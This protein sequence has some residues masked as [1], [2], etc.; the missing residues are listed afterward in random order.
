MAGLIAGSRT[1]QVSGSLQSVCL[2]QNVPEN[3]FKRLALVL[4]VLVFIVLCV[5]NYMLNI[6]VSLITTKYS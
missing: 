3:E 6:Q 5:S 1:Q 4:H 2:S